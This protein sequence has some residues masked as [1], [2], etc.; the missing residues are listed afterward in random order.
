MVYCLQEL[1]AVHK[2]RPIPV[3]VDSPLAI[4]PDRDPPRPPRGLHAAGP[5]PDGQ[6]P[7]LLRLEVRR[8]LRELGRFAAA[9]LHERP[10]GDHRLVG[11]VRGGPDPPPPAARRLRPRQRD[12]DRQLPG[13]GDAGPPDRRG[14]RAGP[15]LRP[16]VRPE[17]RGLRARRLLRPRRPQRPG[18][19]VRADRR[20]DRARPSSSTASPSPSTPWSP[21]FSRSSRAR[22]TPP[23]CT[24]ATRSEP[25]A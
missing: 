23:N 17:R 1:F 4:A 14:G 12:R 19:V 15:D 8:V 22:S 21:C 9:Q 2:V 10:D 24:R 11:H 18:L 13:R 3:Y 5:Q 20:Q 25:P 7:A 6:G 16:V